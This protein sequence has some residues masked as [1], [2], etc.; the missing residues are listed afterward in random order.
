LT[1][2][3][4]NFSLFEIT[5]GQIQGLTLHQRFKLKHFPCTLLNS[6]YVDLKILQFNNHFARFFFEFLKP[7]EFL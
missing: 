5:I 6:A 2:V 7:E 4:Q 1:L 3:Y